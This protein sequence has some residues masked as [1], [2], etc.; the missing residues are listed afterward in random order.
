MERWQLENGNFIDINLS[1]IHKK[2][3]K[4]CNAGINIKEPDP[5]FWKHAKLKPKGRNKLL[6]NMWI[7]PT[8]QIIV[9][10]EHNTLT[11]LENDP[12]QTGKTGLY[13]FPSSTWRH[14]LTYALHLP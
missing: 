9:C 10:S 7:A 12:P 8:T 6:Q 5:N 1:S 2:S 13:M 14:R 3:V 11:M 4:R